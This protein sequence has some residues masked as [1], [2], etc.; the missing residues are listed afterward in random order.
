MMTEKYS[1]TTATQTSN[2]L[3]AQLSVTDFAIL[4]PDL[5]RTLLP[6][7]TSLESRHRVI[8]NIYFP[9][10]GM[11]S[12]EASSGDRKVEAALI[13]REGM[14]GISAM[15]GDCHAAN[16]T[17]V[18]VAGDGWFLPAARLAHA[19]EESSALRHHFL[20][21]AQAF[22]IQTAQNALANARCT[23]N[24]R[25]A[26]WL[27]MAHDRTNQPAIEMTHDKISQIL[28]TRRA[29]ITLALARLEK[30]GIV[31]STRG[32]I[33]IVSRKALEE[34]ANGCYGLPETHYTRLFG[35]TVPQVATD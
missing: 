31:K 7:G 34:A 16:D 12:V 22:F 10:N 18:L 33:A 11:L 35:G 25:V 9:E 5:N 2:L 17:F 30:A 19:I 4:E 20:L 13:G 8:E 32:H 1:T 27:C 3:L 21:Y 23:I 14:T 28:G 15:F 24:E 26:R 29:G 6:V